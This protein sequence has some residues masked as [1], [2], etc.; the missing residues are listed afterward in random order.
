MHRR[1]RVALTRHHEICLMEV[2]NQ[3]M[4]GQCTVQLAGQTQEH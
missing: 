1:I 4:I 2:I 3:T